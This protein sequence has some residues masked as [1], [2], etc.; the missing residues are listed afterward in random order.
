MIIKKIIPYIL[1]QLIMVLPMV[2]SSDLVD[3]VNDR[4]QVSVSDSFDFLANK[5]QQVTFIYTSPTNAKKTDLFGVFF[6]IENLP[7]GNFD[8]VDV[9]RFV[10]GPDQST[11][12]TINLKP[13]EQVIILVENI[14]ISNHRNPEDTVSFDSGNHGIM[15]ANFHRSVIPID[16]GFYIPGLAYQT[17]NLP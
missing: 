15:T 3:V 11:C 12:A 16:L 14:I 9:E 6:Y 17:F 1:S 2:A 5:K 7:S 13:N 4:T 10:L 8:A